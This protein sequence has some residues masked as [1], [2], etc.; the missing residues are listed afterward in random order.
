MWYVVRQVFGENIRLRAKQKNA[1]RREVLA[2]HDK[3]MSY[4]FAAT[5]M[6]PMTTLRAGS[7]GAVDALSRRASKKQKKKQ[8]KAP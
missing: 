1:T 7:S 4:I 2:F 3:W 6:Y 5:D 8:K